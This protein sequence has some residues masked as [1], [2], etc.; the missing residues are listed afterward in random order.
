MAIQNQTLSRRDELAEEFM[1]H[2][3]RLEAIAY[4]NLRMPPAKAIEMLVSLAARDPKVL[5][6]TKLSLWRCLQ[7]SMELGLSIDGAAGQMWVLPFR[8]REKSA[9]SRNGDVYEGTPCVGY[10]GWVTLLQRSGIRMATR[11]QHDGDTWNPRYGTTNELIH[12]PQLNLAE[13]V[14][15]T[16]PDGATNADLQL[17][18]NALVEHAYSVATYEDGHTSFEIMDRSELDE[19]QRR[20]AGSGAWGDAL[21]IRTMWRKS[22]LTK[23]AK[24]LSVGDN[25]TA[26]RAVQVEKHYEET[27]GLHPQNPSGVM[28]LPGMLLDDLE[29][30]TDGE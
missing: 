19:R 8:D 11:L 20:S 13:R 30:S 3:G 2:E 26:E 15:A 4:D 24:D 25:P 7:V 17:A 21:G 1:G 12:A 16:L 14:R 29:E 27:A 28:S 6:C 23:H 10:R 22:V 9:R 5:K 18:M